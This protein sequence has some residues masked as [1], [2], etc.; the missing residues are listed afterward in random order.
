MKAAA[1]YSAGPRRR[2]SGSGLSNPPKL[3]PHF[4][5]QEEALFFLTQNVVVTMSVFH[6]YAPAVV[7]A[8]VGKEVRGSMLESAASRSF[9]AWIANSSL[10]KEDVG[11]GPVVGGIS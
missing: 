6:L 8:L 11:V 2:A 7:R 5:S 4:A 1:R 9:I 3:F 10:D